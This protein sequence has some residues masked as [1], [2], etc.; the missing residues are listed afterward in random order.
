MDSYFAHT[1]LH[2][3]D[4][5][6]RKQFEDVCSWWHAATTLTGGAGVCA[7]VG[8]GGVGKTAIADQ[9]VRSLMDN[10]PRSDSVSLKVEQKPP[11]S[12]FVYSFYEDEKSDSFFR[13]LQMWVEQSP[14]LNPVLSFDQLLFVLQKKSG[15]I[16]LDGLERVQ[17]SRSGGAFGRILCSRLRE[18]LSHV[19]S[20]NAR[21]LSVLVTSRF[22]LTDLVD[23]SARCL[24]SILVDRLE[25]ESCIALL[26]KRGV[27]GSNGQLES[28]AE[29]CGRHALSVNLMGGYLAEFS[30]GDPDAAFVLNQ[31]NDVI[32]DAIEREGDD[33]KRN[34][35]LQNARFS[36]IVDQ[37]RNVICDH[38]EASLALLERICLFRL[39][40]DLDTLLKLFTAKAE[41]NVAGGSLLAMDREQMQRRL[42]WLVRLR[43]IEQVS[44][45]IE[46]YG[47]KSPD[48]TKVVQH[49]TVHPALRE[50]F[51]AA[52]AI[53]D[54]KSIH[55]G[56]RNA[57]SSSSNVNQYVLSLDGQAKSWVST[58]FRSL[59][60]LEEIVHHTR[61][62]GEEDHAWDIYWDKMGNFQHLGLVLCEYERGARICS[63]F[64]DG[65]SPSAV[66]ADTRRDLLSNAA[67]EIPSNSGTINH[68][69]GSRV[70]EWAAYLVRLGRIDEAISLIELAIEIAA[71]TNRYH[72][73]L[74]SQVNLSEFQFKRGRLAQCVEQAQQIQSCQYPDVKCNA[75]LWAGTALAERGEID[76]SFASYVKSL[77]GQHELEPHAPNRPLW[78]T[79]GIKYAELLV[80][81]GRFDEAEKCIEENLAIY[82]PVSEIADAP[83]VYECKLIM[84][85]IATERM[86]FERADKLVSQTMEWAIKRDAKELLCGCYIVQA[87]LKIASLDSEKPNKALMRFTED[88]IRKGLKI[89]SNCGYGLYFID[90]L[91][92]RAKTQFISGNPESALEDVA[93]ALD[94]G[95]KEN[96][97][98]GQP[99]LLSATN[100]KCNYAWGIAIGHQLQAEA[101]LMQAAQLIGNSR[102]RPCLECNAILEGADR[103]RSTCHSCRS[104]EGK[105]AD[106][107]VAIRASG[108]SPD[109]IPE[110]KRIRHF[111]RERFGAELADAT[112]WERFTAMLE[113]EYSLAA[114]DYLRLLIAET[115]DFLKTGNTQS[116][117]RVH[118]SD[119]RLIERGQLLNQASVLVAQAEQHLDKAMTQWHLLRDPTPNAKTNLEINGNE[120]NCQ[121]TK[122]VHIHTLLES[123]LLS[124]YV[125]VVVIPLPSNPNNTIRTV[126]EPKNSENTVKRRAIFLS[127]AHG[128]EEHKKKVY[129]LA[130]SLGRDQFDV[131]IDIKKSTPEDWPLWMQRQI[132]EADFV[133]C[134]CSKLYRERFDADSP[135]NEGLGVGWEGGLI[136]KLL[137]RGKHMNEKFFAVYLCD[138]DEAHVPLT[139]QGYDRFPLFNDSQYH[140]LL[141]KLLAKPKFDL[142]EPLFENPPT[143]L[144][145]EGISPLFSGPQIVFK[146]DRIGG[147]IF[148]MSGTLFLLL[149]SLIFAAALT[150]LHALQPKSISGPIATTTKSAVAS[151]P[152]Y[153]P[154]LNQTLA[155]S[156]SYLR[157]L[158]QLV[159]NTVAELKKQGVKEVEL[160]AFRSNIND[161]IP[162]RKQIE[163]TLGRQLEANQVL[164]RNGSSRSIECD[165]RIVKKSVPPTVGPALGFLWSTTELVLDGEKP[166][167]C[168]AAND[169]ELVAQQLG[170][171]KRMP[172]GDSILL[173]N[174]AVEDQIRNQNSSSVIN[175]SRCRS[176]ESSLYSMEIRVGHAGRPLSKNHGKPFLRFD[177]GERYIVRLH[178]ESD[179]D[180]ASAVYVD[181][182]N[183]LNL[184]GND[185]TEAFFFIPKRGFIDIEGWREDLDGFREFVIAEHNR[186]DVFRNGNAAN[187]GFIAATFHRV[188]IEG[189]SP[190][191]GEPVGKGALATS[192][193]KR[194]Q[195]RVTLLPRCVGVMRDI[196]TIG[197]DY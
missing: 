192:K 128:S 127:Y 155:D 170:L 48:A 186:S 4:W 43:L 119:Q 185:A 193:G 156:E 189:N 62:S 78:T 126:L 122:T 34:V 1:L 123:G 116:F 13:H 111:L 94:I 132:L 41:A 129:G 92:L 65:R 117:E 169:E 68:S 191:E 99:E 144:K 134:V 108:D 72:N 83:D 174:Q 114:N 171:T 102:W 33:D 154:A 9:F 118:D 6:P 110:W 138:E 98:T 145:T 194:I 14:A 147:R 159:R 53:D 57:L 84:A 60:L 164:L 79:R 137:H 11:L 29:T 140:D 50:S 5:Q 177:V 17:E 96:E 121:A 142:I 91:L 165:F 31:N 37:Y 166:K 196:V 54:R 23:A 100:D 24:T 66:V 179:F 151:F 87:R 22:P 139:L 97:V 47:S 15:L 76:E 149:V 19:G 45:N 182:L 89:A 35:L 77:T 28:L 70:N 73:W 3:R 46:N 173:R 16:V 146:T 160:G 67:M 44:G 2:A 82:Q 80:R 63:G 131:R 153:E 148:T 161:D 86:D 51:A 18:F 38:D 135:S 141:R 85:K 81:L 188:W 27:H 69:L 64:F 74:V 172:D 181:G 90:L 143:Q 25:V 195:Q 56:I 42:D 175:G 176:D 150:V 106:L 158:E 115:E 168:I 20:G 10:M 184:P 107:D 112:L 124:T 32:H 197:Y 101:K 93:N 162:V 104:I 136:R 103:D 163:Q 30:N 40:V 152:S 36:N 75:S 105:I 55:R 183:V 178:N 120:Y 7:L 190:P 39:G 125:N 88:T 167:E 21:E 130:T 109:R 61:K 71:T 59:D 180:V 95:I 157:H 187:V 52:L 26:R 133:L 8:I 49:Y 12:V 113:A 58:D